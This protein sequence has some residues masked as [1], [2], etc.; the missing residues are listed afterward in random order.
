MYFNCMIP[1]GLCLGVLMS[2]A[3]ATECLEHSSKAGT[4]DIDNM[5]KPLPISDT[6]SG[7]KLEKD[8]NQVQIYVKA[9]S[10]SSYRQVKAVTT[11]ST[12]LCG[13]VALIKDASASPRWMDRV[14]KYETLQNINDK[15]WYTYAEIGIPWPFKNAD[16]I[17]HNVLTQ[18]T[19][20]KV[21]I[22]IKNA[23]SYIKKYKD[24]ARV[25]QAGGS[26]MLTPEENG[27]KVEYIF[28]AKPEGLS[29]PAWL[30]N[31]ITVQSFHRSIER[32]R[33]LA[34]MQKYR[35]AKLEYIKQP[36]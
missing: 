15:D 32:M 3:V 14:V 4:G 21:T 12:T 29:L 30:V 27:V 9:A 35:T 33:H 34:E 28:H 23:P 2:I 17:T 8:A 36:V 5:I 24:K 10:G 26:W 1:V 19:D 6:E 18:S 11:I 25:L 7:W 20:G 22:D 16:V 13:M 31:S